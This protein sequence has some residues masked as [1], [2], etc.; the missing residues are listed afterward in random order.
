MT[1]IYEPVVFIRDGWMSPDLI[2]IQIFEGDQ[3]EH[4]PRLFEGGLNPFVLRFVQ[5][6]CEMKRTF[7]A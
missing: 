1:S 7:R 2:R 5:A 3:D 6:F 4:T